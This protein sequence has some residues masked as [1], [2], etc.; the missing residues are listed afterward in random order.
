M[1]DKF[2]TLT[3]AL[4]FLE[5]HP[6]LEI[7]KR[8]GTELSYRKECVGWYELLI[9]IP[10]SNFTFLM[11]VYESVVDYGE[12]DLLLFSICKNGNIVAAV[13]FETWKDCIIKEEM[14]PELTGDLKRVANG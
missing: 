4:I 10:N 5:K 12:E 6:N 7:T 1:N 8:Y 13:D 3:S 14:S 9:C 2:R 11:T